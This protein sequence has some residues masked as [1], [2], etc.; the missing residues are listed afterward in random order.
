MSTST[1]LFDVFSE[2]QDFE[3]VDLEGYVVQALRG[4]YSGL[5]RSDALRVWGAAVDAVQGLRDLD[6]EVSLA[7]FRFK[8]V[9]LLPRC[10]GKAIS[11]DNVIHPTACDCPVH[12][13]AADTASN[14][15]RVYVSRAPEVRRE[16]EQWMKNATEYERLRAHLADLLWRYPERRRK[17]GFDD[18]MPDYNL[19]LN[20]FGFEYIRSNWSKDLRPIRDKANHGRGLGRD[21]FVTTSPPS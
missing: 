4:I 5:T 19:T 17:L 16:V 12:G 9:V 11:G 7:I 15:L 21:Q 10:T 6:S 8:A 14:R 3:D 13:L 20:T 18:Y 1:S 2:A